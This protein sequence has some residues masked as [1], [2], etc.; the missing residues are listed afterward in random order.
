MSPRTDSDNEEQAVVLVWPENKALSRATSKAIARA[1]GIASERGM[2]THV[3]RA[4]EERLSQVP[5]R[6]VFVLD[7]GRAHAL[8]RCLHRRRVLV[9]AFD[10]VI[11]P[12]DP[13]RKLTSERKATKLSTFVAHKASYSR[14]SVPTDVVRAFQR[15]DEWVGGEP[16]C[17]G[18]QD[19]RALPLHVFDTAGA[20][21]S[22]LDEVSV[23][24]KF[25][26]CYGHRGILEDASGRSW[27][28]GTS[29]GHADRLVIAGC[30]LGTGAHW[31]VTG[32]G[33][34]ATIM[35]GHEIWQFPRRSAYVN[36]SP[37]AH[38]R[39]GSRG[40]SAKRVWP[41]KQK[42]PRN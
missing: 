1:R 41:R 4:R 9:F 20:D 36:V 8:Y 31:D 5:H 16:G 33:G 11:V 23:N 26:Q 29:H 6:P 10:R 19:P 40:R 14:A 27:E 35:N 22:Q 15:F 18:P 3:C 30:D 28:R 21:W 38:L 24:R 17:D 32:S 25:R 42:M 2:P 12:I 7:A 13:S 37:D 39:G 34:N